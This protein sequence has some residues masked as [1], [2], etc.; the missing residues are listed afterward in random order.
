MNPVWLVWWS[1]LFLC[2][3]C[4]PGVVMRVTQKW[5]DYILSEGKEVFRHMLQ[6]D[7]LP[8]IIGSTH[9]FGYVDYSI[10]GITVEEF[11][12]SHIEVLPTPPT[13]V[14]LNVEGAMAKVFGQW[15][16]KHWLINDNGNFS[17][18]VSGVTL[19]A[20]FTTLK[21]SAS[22][23]SVSLSSCNSEVKNAKVHLS[24]GASWLYNLFTGYLE[25]PIRDNLNN[26]L[27]P[28]VNEAIKILQKELA[29][30]QVTADLDV[31][32]EIDYSLINPPRVQKTYI[33]LDLKGTIHHSGTQEQQE[34]YVPSIILP[35]TIQSMILVGLPEHFFNTL[36]KTYFMS[37]ILM[38]TLTE[39][40]YPHAFWLR[41]GDYGAIIPKMKKYY[42]RS[43]AVIFTMKATKP[44][45]V[46]LTSQLT[47]QLD[48]ILEALVVLP[49]MLKE[50]I[51]AVSVQATFIADMVR[52]SNIKLKVSF[53]MQSF[54]F[55]DFRSSVGHVDLSDLE[56]SLGPMLQD[57][58][59]RAINRGLSSGISMPSLGN[60]TLQESATSIIPGC[61]LMSMDMY[62]IPWKELM[63]ILPEHVS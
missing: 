26:K 30:F 52:L 28:R 62:Y 58:V 16:V 63:V 10:T 55:R 56:H 8:D 39:E 47:M 14:H 37:D 34:A 40:Q 43:E 25:R 32:H 46:L 54:H 48:G 38:L 50:Q 59:V 9:V 4:S 33:E 31:N 13:D 45:V 44:P 21:D 18:R 6:H 41:T 24:G 60:I 27:C 5:L 19:K 23:P 2:G 61:L 3:N 22:R 36:G 1:G 7:H 57:S 42:P 15:R 29:T 51:F 53:F 20:Q 35:D 17:L 49:Y 12:T 11:D